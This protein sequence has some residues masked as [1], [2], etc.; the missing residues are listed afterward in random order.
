V[1]KIERV[2]RIIVKIRYFPEQDHC[3]PRPNN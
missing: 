1:T 3:C 2:M